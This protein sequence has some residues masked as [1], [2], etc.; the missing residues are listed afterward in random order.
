PTD[1]GGWPRRASGTAPAP[2]HS[3]TPAS[4][5]SVVSHVVLVDDEAGSRSGPPHRSRSQIATQTHGCRRAPLRA[6]GQPPGSAQSATPEQ[7]DGRSDQQGDEEHAT[8]GDHRTPQA[9]AMPQW[10]DHLGLVVDVRRLPWV[11]VCVC[12]QRR[13]PPVSSPYSLHIVIFNQ[14]V[15]LMKANDPKAIETFEKCIA[16]CD[17]IGDSAA[18]VKAKAVSVVP[19][20]YYKKAFN[21]LKTD[22]NIPAA[23]AAAKVTL[24][25]A[26]KYNDPNVI[27]SAEQLL[28]QAYTNMASDYINAKDNLN[29][30]LEFDSVLMIN[31]EHLPS[32]YNKALM[33]RSMSDTEKFTETIDLYLGKLKAAGDESKLEQPNKVARDYFRVAGGKANKANNLAE[34]VDLLT[35]A[36][37]YGLDN[38]LC[39]QFASVYNKQKKFDQAAEY[40][41]KGLDLETQTTPEAKA[42]YYYELGTAQAGKGDTAAACESL[43]NAMY[44]PFLPAAKAQRTNMK[45]Q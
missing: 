6:A 23:I 22:K 34:A 9:H 44:G 31:P 15:E 2:S 4:A 10:Q 28:V 14:G 3:L 39:Y 16:L 41:Q 42:K 11:R 7:W 5:P 45:C 8:A 35:K 21:L 40:A 36:S 37:N 32:I 13:Q 17:Q 12:R 33:Y 27:V 19:D 30:I 43:K 20:L 25:I 29:A 38:N 18:D 26:E 24:R 1:P